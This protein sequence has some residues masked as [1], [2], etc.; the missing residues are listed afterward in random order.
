MDFEIGR[1]MVSPPAYIGSKFWLHPCT[2]HN[3]DFWQEGRNEGAI[4]RGIG[5]ISQ[6]LHA[7]LQ[8]DGSWE[9]WIFVRRQV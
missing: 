5:G 9:S 3:W 4:K 2:S 6:E 8:M 7:H 1:G